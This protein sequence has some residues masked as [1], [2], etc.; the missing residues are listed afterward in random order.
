M[1]PQSHQQ[2]VLHD[3]EPDRD[4]FLTAVVEGLQRNQK[5]LPCKYFYD[6][7][8]SLLFDKICNLDEYY[9]TRTE[10]NIMQTQI[11]DISRRIGKDSLLIEFGS[12]SSLKTRILLDNLTNITGYIPIDISKEHLLNSST[13]LEK[14]YPGLPVQPVCADYTGE[15][16]L[17]ENVDHNARR[18]VY[19]PGSTI[20]NFQPE[21]AVIFLHSINKILRNNG[22][23]LIGVDLKKDPVILHRAYNDRSGVTKT[24]NLNLLVRAN[25]ELGANFQTDQFR[26]YA[27]YNPHRG[28]VE[29]HIVSLDDQEVRINGTTISFEKGESIHTESSYKYT[30]HEFE[31][32]ARR[33]GFTIDH[34]WTDEDKFF[35]VQL[36]KLH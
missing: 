1:K 9:P 22:L 23:L 28:R 24:F 29:M 6:E 25:R 27:F 16:N 21:E 2:N 15:F 26:H 35:S 19:F 20:G 33:A 32:L 5:E 30:L 31:K 13:E 7:R 11:D 18:V 12:G 4:E 36:L 17:P 14:Q 34:V 10:L 3:L 8:G